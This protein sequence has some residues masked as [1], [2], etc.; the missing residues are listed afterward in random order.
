MTQ[1][2][3]GHPNSHHLYFNSMDVYEGRESHPSKEKRPLRENFSHKNKTKNN[4]QNGKFYMS[5]TSFSI[6]TS[7]FDLIRY[8][9]QQ[10]NL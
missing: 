10:I 7:L 4:V 9:V 2:F 6:P 3:K 8:S 5:I 1:E